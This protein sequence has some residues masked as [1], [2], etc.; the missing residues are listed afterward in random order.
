MRHQ[1]P[2]DQTKM[3]LDEI[4]NIL[5]QLLAHLSEI[6][7]AFLEYWDIFAEEFGEENL[8]LKPTFKYI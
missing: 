3:A 5:Y 4:S 7:K 8:G 1:L 2:A 6:E